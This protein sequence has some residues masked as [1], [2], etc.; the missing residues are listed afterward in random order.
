MAKPTRLFELPL[1]DLINI[2]NQK[3]KEFAVP[4][5]GSSRKLFIN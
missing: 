1:K 3:I 4:M 5:K 2:V